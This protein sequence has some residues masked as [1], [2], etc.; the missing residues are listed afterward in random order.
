ME[1]SSKYKVGDAV[2]VADENPTGNPRTPH[3]IR[4]KRGVIGAVPRRARK[5]PRSSRRAQA[6][7]HG[8]V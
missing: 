5:Y 4:G 7:L 1:T 2:M 6:A 3:Y 8:Q